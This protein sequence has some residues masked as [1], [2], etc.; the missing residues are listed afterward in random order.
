MPDKSGE[1]RFRCPKCGN[2]RRRRYC[3]FCKAE[4][5]RRRY[6]LDPERERARKRREYRAKAAGKESPR[7]V[8]P[9]DDAI[10]DEQYPGTFFCPSC[11][12]W[13]NSSG[14]LVGDPTAPPAEK[15]KRARG[16]SNAGKAPSPEQSGAKRAYQRD[17]SKM[18]KVKCAHPGCKNTWEAWPQNVK[19]GLLCPQLHLPLLKQQQARERQRRHRQQKRRE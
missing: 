6:A 14:E 7:I 11:G 19:P 10:Q 5:E 17:P 8:C 2:L 9:H 16:G 12:A 3:K 4:A 15:P 18:V 13:L 1:R